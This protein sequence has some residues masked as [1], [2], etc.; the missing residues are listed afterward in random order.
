MS[1]TG[2]SEYDLK[3]VE[4]RIKEALYRESPALGYARANGLIKK[5]PPGKR[6]S[7]FWKNDKMP[8]PKIIDRLSGADD[9]KVTMQPTDTDI[10]HFGIKV[11]VNQMSLDA[12]ANNQLLANRDLIALSINEQLQKFIEMEDAFILN[13]TNMYDYDSSDPLQGT[14]IATG[15]MNGFTSISGGEGTDDVMTAQNDFEATVNTAIKAMAAAGISAPVDII[16]DFDVWNAAG[17]GNNYFSTVGE[18][19]REK[20]IKR[21]DVRQ[22]IPMIHAENGDGDHHMAIM[23]PKVRNKPSFHVVMSYENQ[24]YPAY[25]GALSGD[26]NYE[27]FIVAG[28]AVEEVRANAVQRTGGTLTTLTLT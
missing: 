9:A 12:A 15:T 5:V 17:E 27:F 20:I 25:D 3:Y 22:W 18:K 13:G 10:I 28:L 26:G 11:K 6:T 24:V 8:K 4:T 1:K 21:S 16:S 23:Q 7:T 2:L 19:E 14:S